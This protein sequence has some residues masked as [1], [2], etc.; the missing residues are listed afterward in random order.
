MPHLADAS[1]NRALEF[2]LDHAQAVLTRTPHVLRAML[3]GMPMEWVSATESEGSWSPFDVLGHLI[4][5]ERTDWIPRARII[6]DAGETKPFEPFDR[7][8]QF[9]NSR[10]QTINEL[11]DT[12]TELR[13]EN[14][15]TLSEMG[16]KA[17]DLE[18]TGMHPELGRVTLAQLIATWVAH[19]LGHI[20]QITRTMARQY[21]EAVGP[22]RAYLSVL[23]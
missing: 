5:G 7:F 18:K 10:G 16:L 22:W 2:R 8:A 11:L 23:K 14:L 15:R 20:V 9:E 3:E 12:F 17:E 1:G 13:V 6:L 4:H 19:D 21:K